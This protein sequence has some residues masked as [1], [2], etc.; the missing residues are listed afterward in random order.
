MSSEEVKDLQD[1]Y[2]KEM[3]DFNSGNRKKVVS[4]G[5]LYAK[6]GFKIGKFTVWL[7]VGWADLKRWV[8]KLVEKIKKSYGKLLMKWPP[9]EVERIFKSVDNYCDKC[10]H[11]FKISRMMVSSY[12]KKTGKKQWEEVVVVGTG[13]KCCRGV[14]QYTI[15]YYN[16]SCVNLMLEQD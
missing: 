15:P 14:K 7:S 12:D 6:K 9:E 5:G 13:K 4:I 11:K 1:G 8:G 16:D 10:G 2:R 3:E